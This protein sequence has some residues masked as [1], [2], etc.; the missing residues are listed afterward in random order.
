MIL[1]VIGFVPVVVL[2]WVLE[3]TPDGLRRETDV[4]RESRPALGGYQ[5]IFC[6]GMFGS[7]GYDARV[8]EESVVWIGLE[9]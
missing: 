3:W 6:N 5:D 4:V 7:L 9:A 2:A 1:I 8:V